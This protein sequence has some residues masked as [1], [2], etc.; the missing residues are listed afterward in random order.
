MKPVFFL[1]LALL[2]LR[3]RTGEKPVTSARKQIGV[4]LRYFPVITG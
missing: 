3:A 1:L 2:P 4:T